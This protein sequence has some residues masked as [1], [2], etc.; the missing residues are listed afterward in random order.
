MDKNKIA[1]INE[2]SRKQRSEGLTEAEK[3]EQKALRDEYR[4]NIR[5]SLEEKIDNI[6][7]KM[8]DGSV[9]KATDKPKE[10]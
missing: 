8:P 9:V 6:Y 4:A 3:A 1:R 2:L 5:S 7:Y 10:N